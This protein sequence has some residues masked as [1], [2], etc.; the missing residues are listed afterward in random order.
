MVNIFN[1][2]PDSVKARILLIHHHFNKLKADNQKSSLNLW[3]NMEKQTMKLRRKKRLLNLF[4]FH[5]IDL[6]LHGHLHENHEYYRRGLRFFNA[7]SSIKGKIPGEM[8]IN[9]IEIDYPQ[10]IT[11]THKLVS[12]SSVIIHRNK[13]LSRQVVLNKELKPAVNY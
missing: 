8:Q 12:N 9:F 3:Q 6:I 13:G 7:G 4:N 10:I 1:K 5:G 11:E 2:I